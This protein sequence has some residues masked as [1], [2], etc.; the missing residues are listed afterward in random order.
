MVLLDLRFCTFVSDG[1]AS[2][3]GVVIGNSIAGVTHLKDQLLDS[4]DV[5][6]DFLG[7]LFTAHHA[8]RPERLAIGDHAKLDASV[9]IDLVVNAN[10]G[11]EP[12]G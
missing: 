5:D 11:R 3:V 12:P 7:R 4:G 1:R 10:P 2:P 8:A 9:A 6:I